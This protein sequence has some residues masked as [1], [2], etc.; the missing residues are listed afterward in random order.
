MT[1]HIL[2]RPKRLGLLL[3]ALGVI[4]GLAAG[5]KSGSGGP[6]VQTDYDPHVNFAQYH[7]F[8]FQRGR[9]VS[10]LGTNDTDNT[11]L[12]NRI[13]TA[14]ESDLPVKNLFQNARLGS[15]SCQ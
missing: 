12:D 13:R 8:A 10:R 6:N 4:G 7:T 2:S 5:C 11:L 3:L 9:I 1:R 14:V 15:R